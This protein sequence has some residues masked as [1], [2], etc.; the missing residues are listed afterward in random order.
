MFKKIGFIALSLMGAALFF[1]PMEAEAAKVKIQPSITFKNSYNN[2]VPARRVYVPQ[3][4][5]VRH[6]VYNAPYYHEDVVI[7]EQP[8]Q[9]YY[10]PYPVYPCNSG[11]NFSLG[12]KFR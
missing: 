12:F 2:Y 7:Y 9:Y 4:P 8:P 11:V 3:P 10:R 1:A 6:Y 5:V